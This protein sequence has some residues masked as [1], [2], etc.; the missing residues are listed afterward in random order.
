[1]MVSNFPIKVILDKRDAEKELNDLRKAGNDQI[2]GAQAGTPGLTTQ[3]EGLAASA[4]SAIL[5]FIRSALAVG[6]AVQAV[7][8]FSTSVAEQ[9]RSLGVATQASVDYLDNKYLE[10]RAQSEL[11]TQFLTTIGV[12]DSLSD[13]S[14]LYRDCLLYTSPS[15]RDS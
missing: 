13:A 6:G 10:Q 1:M 8:S 7:K 2:G 15:P 11:V 3:V 12:Y 4:R 14:D 5:P 9:A